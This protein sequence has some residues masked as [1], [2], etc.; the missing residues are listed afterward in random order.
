MANAD[1][2]VPGQILLFVQLNDLYQI[3]T[4]SDYTRENALILPR[5]STL[6]GHLRKKFGEHRVRFCIPGD[7]LAPS[8]L[9]KEFKGAQMIDVLNLMSVDYVSLG[10]H[11][12]D[13]IDAAAFE[14]RVKESRFKWLNLNFEFKDPALQRRLEHEGKMVPFDFVPITNSHSAAIFGVLGVKDTP[15][16]L[17]TVH[18]EPAEFLSEMLDGIRSAQERALQRDPSRRVDFTYVAMTHQKLEDDLAMPGAC[19]GLDLIMGGHDHNVTEEYREGR[20]VIVK[21]ASNARTL[22]LNWIVVIPRNSAEGAALPDMHAERE[23][24]RE[25]ARN[26]VAFSGIHPLRD[27]LLPMQ[28]LSEQQYADG[29]E[30]FTNNGLMSRARVI[31]NDLVFAFSVRLDT[32]S[33][34][35]MRL[36]AP[37]PAVH[38]RIR[39]WN[40]RC[41]HSEVPLAI[42]PE[43]LILEDRIVRRFSSNFGNFIADMFRGSLISHPTIL[44]EADVGLVN[45]G[46]FRIDRNIQCG[47]AVSLRTL[48]DIFYHP[49]SINLY[50]ISGA[51]L[52]GVLGKAL[53][54]R[55]ADQNEG[56]GDF[57]QIAGIKVTVDQGNRISVHR[58]SAFGTSTPLDGTSE[59]TVATTPYVAGRAYREYFTSPPLRELHNDVSC[60]VE[61]VLKGMDTDLFGIYLNSAPRWTFVEASS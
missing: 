28:T 60:C 10:N 22:R 47:E 36:V 49:N 29:L 39:N 40:A 11:E 12:F 37:D 32:Q 53:A 27:A 5:I 30:L 35:F 46:S 55:N 51:D 3:D 9:S 57:L 43:E 52:L 59:L 33:Q 20:C 54:L 15:S 61:E 41:V 44:E 58:V 19:P 45:S 17:G 6:V 24:F 31:G 34:A 25:F 2:T 26:V 7:F 42:A 16:H 56:D 14:D 18:D 13:G 48:C 1:A 50:R 38:S 4:S 8:C 23:R 21:T